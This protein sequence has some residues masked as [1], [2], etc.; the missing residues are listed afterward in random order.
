M[1]Q[2]RTKPAAQNP[3][4][5]AA[6]PPGSWASAVL[7]RLAALESRVQELENHPNGCTCTRCT[8]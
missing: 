7:E 2:A 1:R 4:P 5:Q 6:K 8:G 3:A